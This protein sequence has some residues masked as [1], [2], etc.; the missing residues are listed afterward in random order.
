MAERC[1]MQKTEMGSVNDVGILVL[2]SLGTGLVRSK[3]WIT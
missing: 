1:I 3:R 2:T